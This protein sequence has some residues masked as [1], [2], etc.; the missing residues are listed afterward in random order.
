MSAPQ[1]CPCGGI[2]IHTQWGAGD[3][4][5]IAAQITCDRCMAHSDI[6]KFRSAL[7]LERYVVRNWNRSVMHWTKYDIQFSPRPL[8]A[9]P[10]GGL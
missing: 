6:L 7:E 8:P 10:R 2:P 1:P 4:K 5:R 9:T 3:G